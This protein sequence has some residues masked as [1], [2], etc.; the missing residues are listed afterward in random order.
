MN[1][2]T[3][4]NFEVNKFGFQEIDPIREGQFPVTIGTFNTLAEDQELIESFSPIQIQTTEQF[5]NQDAGINVNTSNDLNT[6][7][8]NLE[9]NNENPQCSGEYLH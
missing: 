3:T 5:P 4:A 9:D 8:L 7:Y 1:R 2:E 6:K